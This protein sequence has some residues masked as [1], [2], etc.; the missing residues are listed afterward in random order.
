MTTFEPI[1]LLPILAYVALAHITGLRTINKVRQRKEL[2]D[3]IVISIVCL[4]TFGLFRVVLLSMIW[5]DKIVTPGN[6][7]PEEAIE[8][9]IYFGAIDTFLICINIF[10]MCKSPN[11][12]TKSKK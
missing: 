3:V 10:Q 6:F 5:T 2:G 4:I 12:T 8:T 1:Y 9:V 7:T 11:A